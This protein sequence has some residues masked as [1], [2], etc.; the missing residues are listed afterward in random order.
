MKGGGWR[1]R[2]RKDVVKDKASAFLKER[3]IL[4][5]YRLQVRCP[6]QSMKDKKIHQRALGLL[7]G[8]WIGLLATR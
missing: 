6:C 3:K 8:N 2:G 7:Q 1:T 4:P 5:L